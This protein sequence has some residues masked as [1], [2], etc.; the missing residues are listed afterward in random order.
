MR[1]RVGLREH[2]RRGNATSILIVAGHTSPSG[3]RYVRAVRLEEV[4]R[5]VIAAC[6]QLTDV[7]AIGGRHEMPP[8]IAGVARSDLLSENTP[9][10]W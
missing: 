5:G 9:P 10:S 2:F 3:L 7:A 8:G 1:Q 6:K 4:N